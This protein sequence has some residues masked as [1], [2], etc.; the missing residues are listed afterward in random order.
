MPDVSA[1]TQDL[2]R[3]QCEWSAFSCQIFPSES[4]R[5]RLHPGLRGRWMGGGVQNLL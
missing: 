2:S 3:R 4:V 1:G 5:A